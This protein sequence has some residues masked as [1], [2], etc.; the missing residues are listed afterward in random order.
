[1]DVVKRFEVWLVPLD[2]SVGSELRKTWP[3]IV[4]SPDETNRHLNT[5]IVVPLTTAEHSYAFRLDLEFL[6]R[7][8]Q[9]AVDQVRV[10]DKNR[11]I[12]LVGQLDEIA[13]QKLLASIRVY[14]T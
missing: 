13:G 7:K 12:K 11:L 8:A 5:I 1:M 4:V 2:P 10:L 9:A 3:F 6:D 14:F